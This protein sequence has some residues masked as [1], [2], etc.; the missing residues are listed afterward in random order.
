MSFRIRRRKFLQGTAAMGFMPLATGCPPTTGGDG[1]VDAGIVWPTL[2]PSDYDGGVKSTFDAEAIALDDV[3]F[4]LGVQAGEPDTESATFWTKTTLASAVLVVWRETDEAG[5]VVIVHEAPHT[6][7][8]SSTIVAREG[9]MAPATWYRY[10][11][12]AV[13][14]NGAKSARST[15]GRVRTAFPDDWRL[16]FTLACATCTNA[17]HQPWKALEET[18]KHDYDLFCHLGD[19]SYNDGAVSVGE[20]DAKWAQALGDPGYRAVLPRAGIV[21]TWDD[22]E[23]T[24]NLNPQTVDDALMTNAKASFFANVP[25]QK[26]DGASI[27]GV[28]GRDDSLF[29]SIRFGHT[30]EVIVLDGRTQRDPASMQTS[31]TAY[32]GDAQTVF[33]KDALKNSP[34]RFK[35]VLNSVPITRM[36]ELWAFANDRWQGYVA[37]RDD[38]LRFLEDEA[39]DDVWFLAGD[40][41]MGFVGR[42][43]PAGYARKFWEIAVGPTGNLG[44]P[45]GLLAAQDEYRESVFPADQYTYGRGKLAA[46]LLTFDPY[47]G[48]VRIRFIDGANGETLYDEELVSVG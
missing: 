9:G 35:I 34:C 47:S 22:H 39:I 32:L 41:H 17:E 45:L 38:L 14:D 26:V 43:E 4:S 5:Q 3:L 29:K 1:G 13:D 33:L 31:T 11:F 21:A 30:A 15:I 27:G 23:I 42:V 8:A 10:A 40:F 37:Q 18:A 25:M 36:P 16:P 19:M 46:T 2:D 28:S 44:N 20:F 12:F 6:A 48:K 7:G 24:N